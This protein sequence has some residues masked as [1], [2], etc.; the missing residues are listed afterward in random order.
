MFRI[1]SQRPEVEFRCSSR[2]SAQPFQATYSSYNISQRK[3]GITQRQDAPEEMTQVTGCSG[4]DGNDLGHA[5][6]YFKTNKRRKE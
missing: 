6:I 4:G 5:K 1:A 3:Q 2:N